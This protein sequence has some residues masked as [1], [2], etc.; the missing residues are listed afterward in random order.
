LAP[1]KCSPASAPFPRPA[2]QR[3]IWL[4]RRLFAAG[5]GFLYPEALSHQTAMHGSWSVTSEEAQ[6]HLVYPTRAVGDNLTVVYELAGASD[7]PPGRH[8]FSSGGGDAA[9]TLLSAP[10]TVPTLQAAQGELALADG[11]T[12]RGGA[13][14]RCIRA[15]PPARC[16]DYRRSAPVLVRRG[17]GRR[18]RFRGC[19]HEPLAG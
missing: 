15:R 1:P 5:G 10:Y 16:A 12:G 9:L 4:S 11:D 6:S 13:V 7:P 2:T 8:G 17:A 14:R 18:R 3:D 19:A